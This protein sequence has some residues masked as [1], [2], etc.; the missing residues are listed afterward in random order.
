M[1]EPNVREVNWM[2]EQTKIKEQPR[3][4]RHVCTP[5]LTV[6]HDVTG[7]DRWYKMIP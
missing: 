3:S 5:L 2:K 4:N 1:K 6:L 7:L